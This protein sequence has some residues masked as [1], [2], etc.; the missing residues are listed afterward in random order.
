MEVIIG[1]SIGVFNI[2]LGVFV[3]WIFSTALSNKTDIKVLD[4]KIGN[5]QN[6]LQ[7]E[8]EIEQIKINSKLQKL[9]NYVKNID[10]IE[11]I[12]LLKK[13][14]KNILNE[15]NLIMYELDNLQH[16]NAV[17]IKKIKGEI[18]SIK[19]YLNKKI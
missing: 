5:L 12:D 16:E 6:I 4:E 1:L 7:K 19:K 18:N 10:K 17:E 13:N 2:I 3:T 15:V 14:I 9:Y 11:D 8:G